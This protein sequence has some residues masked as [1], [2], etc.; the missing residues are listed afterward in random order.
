MNNDQ[1]DTRLTGET[2]PVSNEKGPNLNANLN[3]GLMKL[4]LGNLVSE[5]IYV[6]VQLN[7][8]GLLKDQ[9]RT[10]E[11]L[12][13]ATGTKP[14]ALYRLLRVLVSV[15]IL[16][17]ITSHRFGLTQMGQLLQEGV[18]GSVY[19]TVLFFGSPRARKIWEN[20]LYS[21]QTGENA[22]QYVFGVPTWQ[23]YAQHPQE[24][25]IFYN[26]M[27]ESSN[28]IA[29][30]LTENYNFERVKVVADIGGAQGNML[31]AILKA[32]PQLK[33]ILFDLPQITQGAQDHL[34][35]EGIAD[36]C[37][38]IGGDMFAPWPFKA[39]LYLISRV[40]ENWSDEQAIAI[41]KNCREAMDADSKVVLVERIP[42]E[43]KDAAL[44]FYLFDLQMLVGPGG[45]DH[46]LK[47]YQSFFKAAGLSFTRAIP[48]NP[49][50]S[51]IEAV[52]GQT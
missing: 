3:T 37:Q 2:P 20:L 50:F 16:D 48:I 12:A 7:L 17:E 19:T 4:V 11:E 30:S 47:E 33:G 38:I 5:I 49:P 23:Y 51:L 41:L 6:A 10:D 14:A 18:P 39:D 52:A 35:K 24:A 26:F 43:D 22:N 42:P 40:I 31:A 21:V 32:N 27:T 9:A 15:G 45:Q 28:Q 1:P 29:P 13:G 36:R 34:K 46:N 25:P 8:A 44:L